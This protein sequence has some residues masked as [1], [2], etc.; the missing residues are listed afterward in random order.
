MKKLKF[1]VFGQTMSVERKH[2]QWLLYRESA[3]S[4]KARIYDV[5]IPP[6]LDPDEI[7]RYLADIFHENATQEH[8]DV[9]RE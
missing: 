2:D 1:S 5:V 8:P 3:T 9:T 7:G 6:E 4:I